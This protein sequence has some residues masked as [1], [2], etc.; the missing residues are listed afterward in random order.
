[1]KK[2]CTN[3]LYIGY[4]DRT[5]HGSVKTESALWMIAFVLAFTGVF[6]NELWLPATIVF[7]LSIFYTLTLF[8]IKICV[9]PRCGHDAMIPLNTPKADEIIG[10]SHLTVPRDIADPSR[11]FWGFTL[12]DVLLILTSI[13][14]AIILY[15]EFA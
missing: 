9:C 12:R 5:S 7:A 13:L 8:K 14:I 4:E 6:E 3:C 10:E 15:N 2:L 1:M 11:T